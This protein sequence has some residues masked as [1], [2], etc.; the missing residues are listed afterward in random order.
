MA[1]PNQVQAALDAA[2][3]TLAAVNAQQGEQPP[4]DA[5]AAAD[6]PQP[7]PQAAPEI[8][9]P[10][11]QPAKD[12]PWEARYSVLRGKYDAEVPLLHRKV[13]MLE[14][15]LQAA[16]GRLNATPAPRAEPEQSE[17]DP[18][19]VAAFVEDLVKMVG[20]MSK[21]TAASSVRALEA[22]IADLE[23]QLVDQSEQLKG[24]SS[25][26]AMTAEQT[27]FDRLSK[28]L[29]AWQQVNADKGFLAWLAEED[30]VYGVQRQQALAAAQKRLD[31]DRVAAVFRAYTGTSTKDKSS[32]LDSMVSPK[33]AATVAPTPSEKPVFT[34]AQV[35][36]FYDDVRRG[37]Y[38]GNDTE[39]ARIEGL[40]NAA[41]SEGRIR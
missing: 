26:V 3:A 33:G 18:K 38:R 28:V 9:A 32:P 6:A 14:S 22:K 16:I 24:T 35:T 2:D 8:A 41:L 31:V 39:F 23:K 12:E 40:I 37:K 10:A 34:Q 20:R 4:E 15:E 1:L 21:S 25:Q 30:P 27:F 13:S 11:P 7:E 5:F 36:S 29:P 19:D 17:V